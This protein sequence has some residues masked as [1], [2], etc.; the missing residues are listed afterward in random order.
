MPQPATP[1]LYFP[2]PDAWREWLAEHHDSAS[3]VLVG[4]YKAATGRPTMT[5]PQSVDEALCYGWIDGVRR[6][7]DDERYSIRFTPRKTTSIWSAVNIRRIAELEGEGRMQPTGRS[8][9]ERRRE[10]RSAIYSYEQRPEILPDALPEPYAAILRAKAKAWDF[11]ERQPPSYRRAA[12]WWVVSAR[13]EATRLKRLGELVA[14][15]ARSRRLAR[16][17]RP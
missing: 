8:A 2:S 7:V 13:R 14:D 12:I 6:R 1:A 3:E 15:S 4:F 17:S 16:F 11:F 9:F 10:S 5:W